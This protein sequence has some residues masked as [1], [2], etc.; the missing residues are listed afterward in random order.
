MTEYNRHL[1]LAVTVQLQRIP[2]TAAVPVQ[3]SPLVRVWLERQP[4]GS[5][6]WVH[7]HWKGTPR[8]RTVVCDAGETDCAAFI[9][10]H[11]GHVVAGKYRATVNMADIDTQV[12]P[13]IG[14]V[15]FTWTAVDDAYSRLETWYRFV[16]LAFA[17]I[18]LLLFAF[19]L[20]HYRLSDWNLEQ[21]WLLPL[22]LLLL[23]Y[24]GPFVALEL[25]VSSVV[26]VVLDALFQCA[27]LATLLL[28]WLT[29][30]RSLS[31]PST[32]SSVRSNNRLGS[33]SRIGSS[34]VG[35]GGGASGTS[36]AGHCRN[37]WSPLVLSKTLLCALLFILA[38]AL[39]LIQAI[40]AHH[41]PTYFTHADLTGYTAARV[42]F[43][44]LLSCYLVYVLTLMLMAA[45][46]AHALHYPGTPSS[47]IFFLFFS[48]IPLSLCLTSLVLLLLMLMMMM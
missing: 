28:F 30:F 17:F 41:D 47:P 37:C 27:F 15:L 45:A 7:V 9:A 10:V 1:W 31:A 36:S 13:P 42:L 3:L 39:S 24:N 26:P 29:F 14:D 20:R 8:L 19:S 23:L 12:S 5:A 46:N 21:R 4:V 34:G 43:F 11:V 35:V 38:L 18:A 25:L 32:L 48:W 33:A 16:F 44:I 2:A 22:L 6:E 40:A